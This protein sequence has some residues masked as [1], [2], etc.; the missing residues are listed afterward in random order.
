M[1]SIELANDTEKMYSRND[2]I[3]DASTKYLL[4]KHS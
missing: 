4:D 2:L 3:V 1:A